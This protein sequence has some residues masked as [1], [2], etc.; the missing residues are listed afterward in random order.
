MR[1]N[2][3]KDNGND[4]DPASATNRHKNPDEGVPIPRS[5]PGIERISRRHNS[6]SRGLL[7]SEG[8]TWP[9]QPP[10]RIPPGAIP[11]LVDL[12]LSGSPSADPESLPLHTA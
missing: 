8:W 12:K 7:E 5:G 4:H 6:F 11:K 2:Q 1:D 10:P 3:E 9:S